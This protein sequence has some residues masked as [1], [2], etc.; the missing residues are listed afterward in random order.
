MQT[1]QHA[2]AALAGEKRSGQRM[3]NAHHTTLV[4]RRVAAGEQSPKV[5]PEGTLKRC[6]MS[7][8]DDVDG[9]E[10]EKIYRNRA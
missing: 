2:G 10:P 6:M 5:R 8:D 9:G 7:H 3:C 4:Q 1:G